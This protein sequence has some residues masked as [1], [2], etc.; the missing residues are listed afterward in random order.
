M[1]RRGN[2]IRF[3]LVSATVPN[4][5]DIAL[6]IE[7][8][9]RQTE[10]AQV[11]EFGDEYRP[12]KLTRHVVGVPRR[13]GTNDFAFAKILDKTLFS[14]LQQYSVMKPIL[15]FC[16]T[17]K[18]VFATADTLIKE[19][20]EG[21]KK[22]VSLPW[23]RP[24]RISHSFSDKRLNDLAAVGIGV[25]HAG[26]TLEDRRATENLYLTKVLRILIATSTLA[27]GVN[28]PAHMVVIKGVKTF[29]NNMCREYSDL[30][31]MQMLGRAGRPQY[32]KDGIAVI[33]CETELETKYKTLVQGKTI[34]ESSLHTNLVEHLNSEIGLGTITD[35]MSAKTWL[36]S[37]FL[38]QRMLKN[39]NYYALIPGNDTRE[40]QMDLDEVVMDSIQKLKKNQLIEYAEVGEGA[41][42][43]C[44]T[45]YGEIMSKYYIRR[46]TMELILEMP[47]KPTLREILQT[48]CGAEEFQD[49]KLRASEKAAF[50]ALR[51]DVD[52]R[53]EVKKVEKTADKVFLLVQAVLGGITFNN[54]NYKSV[55]SQPHLEAFSVFKHIV[56]VA[57]GALDVAVVKKDGLQIKNG[58]EL[59]RCLS[60]KAWE[61]RAIVFRQ[62]EHIGE[63]SIKVLAEHG[64]TSLDILRKQNPLRIETLLNRRP[65]FGL[66]VLSCLAEFPQYMIKIKPIEIHSDG[67]TNPVEIDLEIE[68]SLL[69][70]TNAPTK[71]KK[72]RSRSFQMTALLT[73]TSDNELID[74]RRIPTKALKGGKSF[75]V[76]VKLA[77]P[78]QSI[79]VLVSSETLAGTAFQQ[80]YKPSLPPSEYPTPDTRPISSLELDLAGLDDD[81]DFWNMSVD[82]IEPPDSKDVKSEVRNAKTHP[83][84]IGSKT[85]SDKADSRLR[86][87]GKYDCNH[88][89][90]DKTK[91][92]H[93]CCRDGLRDPPPV[94][95][96]KVPDNTVDEANPKPRS[97]LQRIAPIP[98]QGASNKENKILTQLDA[99]H[100]QSNVADNLQISDGQRLKLEPSRTTKRKREPSV[101]YNITFTDL[102]ESSTSR[103]RFDIP[104]CESDSDELPETILKVSRTRG[105]NVQDRSKSDNKTVTPKRTSST[106]RTERPTSSHGPKE[107]NARDE[108]QSKRTKYNEVKKEELF[109]VASD[110]EGSIEM[111]S[112]KPVTKL[113]QKTPARKT[114]KEDDERLEE[115]GRPFYPSL[116]GSRTQ[117]TASVESERAETKTEEDEEF[118][119]LDAWLESGSVVIL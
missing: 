36:R 38:Y 95:R 94:P 103:S 118:A 16:S 110:S 100:E 81:P 79:T 40:R 77:K 88:A 26:L 9:H 57:R 51:K 8:G 116:S 108:S 24:N 112:P 115:Q 104:E 35:I 80:V 27:V 101:G 102:G 14:V 18:G 7:D 84:A 47:E 5:R 42:S 76:S 74:L 60:A 87:D 33:I 43:L 70:G 29:Q 62:I 6:W 61:D 92:R 106:K 3:M 86:P 28:L 97:S 10:P 58:L 19:F 68:C 111:S 4:I 22:K 98:S 54:P 66:E 96:K 59:V 90:K 52:I 30:D 2:S 99:I 37:T 91:C 46:A 65:P 56:R 69:E 63:K 93:M 75:Q 15:V 67:G 78:S 44:S 12:C 23:S 49:V 13:N 34:L 64:I 11:F 31:I 55:D 21:E 114:S 45:Q 41:G 39:P 119:E 109:L 53:F 17:R 73:L 72:H 83:P 117:N 25:H 20:C 48:I 89:C 82:S 85:K 32:D 107:G 50:N 71:T 113:E 105:K 1:K